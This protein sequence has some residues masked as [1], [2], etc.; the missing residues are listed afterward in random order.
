MNCR[1]RVALRA[2]R[3]PTR[4]SESIHCRYLLAVKLPMLTA[5]MTKPRSIGL[6]N[7]K[8]SYGHLLTRL[9]SR[10]EKQQTIRPP[11]PEDLTAPPQGSSD[12]E[13]VRVDSEFEDDARPPKRRKTSIETEWGLK[14]ERSLSPNQS[15]NAAGTFVCEPS[16]IPPSSFVSATSHGRDSDEEGPFGSS[17]TNRGKVYR[18]GVKN[19]HTSSPKGKPKGAANKASSPSRSQDTGGF[20]SKDL[21]G[22]FKLGNWTAAQALISHRLI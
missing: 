8:L 13:S 15:E 1:I 10:T 17:Q 21:R 19:I 5:S 22:M 12:D 9:S 7:E 20:R 6:K 4:R 3:S 16:H 18:R 2:C 14:K 11:T